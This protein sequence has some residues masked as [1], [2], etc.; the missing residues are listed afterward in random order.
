VSVT[1]P[2]DRPTAILILNHFASRELNALYASIAATCEG[3]F[4]VW[5][6]SD[7][8]QISLGRTPREMREFAFTRTDLEA[9][10]YPGRAQIRHAF[11]GRRNMALGHADLPVLLFRSRYPHYR[12]FWIVEY[13]VRWTGAWIEFFDAFAESP[14]DLLGTTVNRYPECPQWSHWNSLAL[15]TV[16]VDQADWVRGFFPVYRISARALDCID[17]AYREGNR[18]HME[19]LM[20]NV[21]HAAGLVIEDVGGSG[22][23]VAPGNRNRFYDNTPTANNLSPGSFVYRPERPAPG[24]EAERLWHPVKPNENALLRLVERGLNRILRP[25]RAPSSAPRFGEPR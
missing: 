23:F 22:S 9:L 3:P 5:L 13:D 6:L 16:E 2:D 8:T 15:T 4:E 19:A 24:A 17:A 12:Q 21:L 25:R 18:G 1:G 11:G 14:A 10:G 7:R 20:P